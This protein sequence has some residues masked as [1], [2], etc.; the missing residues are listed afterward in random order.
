MLYDYL[1]L[2]YLLYFSGIFSGPSILLKILIFSSISYSILSL[3]LSQFK[4]K[5]SS[6]RRSKDRAQQSLVSASKSL[7]QVEIF[8]FLILNFLLH[9][10]ILGYFF[11]HDLLLNFIFMNDIYIFYWPTDEI[12]SWSGLVGLPSSGS[13][14]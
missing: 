12:L 1:I 8:P 9:Y 3:L 6:N 11:I 10:L 2:F 7:R 14:H 5:I 13:N 4:K